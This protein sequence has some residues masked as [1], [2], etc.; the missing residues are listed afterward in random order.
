MRQYTSIKLYLKIHIK[1]NNVKRMKQYYQFLE[2]H[3]N[4]LDLYKIQDNLYKLFLDLQITNYYEH[5]KRS[6]ACRSHL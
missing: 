5:G 6:L 4:N 1:I 2:Y 3:M